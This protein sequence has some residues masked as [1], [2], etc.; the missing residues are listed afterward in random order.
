MIISRL[1]MVPC[2]CYVLRHHDLS[3]SFNS[4]LCIAIVTRKIVMSWIPSACLRDLIM[5]YQKTNLSLHV[6]ISCTRWILTFSPHGKFVAF[7]I[8][9]YCLLVSFTYSV[10]LRLNSGAIFLS[11]FPIVLFG[12]LD[13]QLQA[14]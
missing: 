14:R 8:L 13:S 1:E 4:F 11:V 5:D 12:F 7:L 2:L 9:F 6:S 3:C 10:F